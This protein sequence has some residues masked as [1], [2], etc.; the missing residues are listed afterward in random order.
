MFAETSLID[1]EP[2]CFDQL[3]VREASVAS[4]ARY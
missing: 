4:V 2:I 1:V 3:F